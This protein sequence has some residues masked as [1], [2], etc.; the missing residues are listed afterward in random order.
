MK[1]TILAASLVLSGMLFV[2]G[3]SGSALA[4]DR[5]MRFS[6]PGIT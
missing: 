2:S 1:Q 4:A 6:V 3:L 5:T